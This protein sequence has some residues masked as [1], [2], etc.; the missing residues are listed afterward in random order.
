M[1]VLS[2]LTSNPE[3]HAVAMGK[4][5]RLSVQYEKHEI[6]ELASKQRNARS[7]IMTVLELCG[8]P[9]LSLPQLNDYDLTLQ[10]LILM[11]FTLF[12]F[13]DSS[14]SIRFFLFHTV[15]HIYC[16]CIIFLL[17]SHSF[18]VS[19]SLFFMYSSLN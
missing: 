3:V 9:Q 14:H 6:R 13:S 18:A 1:R 11:C 16:T 19:S 10:S 4:Q 17:F 5:R 8:I 15:K 7:R 2:A 12:G